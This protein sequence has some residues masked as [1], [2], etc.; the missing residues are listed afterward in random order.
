LVVGLKKQVAIFVEGPGDSQVDSA[1][2]SQDDFIKR[3]SD[4]PNMRNRPNLGA[5]CGGITSLSHPAFAKLQLYSQYAKKTGKIL[6]ISQFFC[7]FA[8]K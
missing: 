4:N 6:I 1:A 5:E 7:I 3:A 8:H 2:A